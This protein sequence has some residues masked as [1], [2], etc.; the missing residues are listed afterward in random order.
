MVVVGGGSAGIGVTASLLKRRPTLRVAIIEPSDKHYYQPAW[1]LV[2][3]GAYD[4]AE[5]VKPMV[6]IIPRNAEWIQ[7]AASGFDPE[8][9]R[10]HLSDGR[11]M[12]YRQLIVC[13]GIRL[14]WEKI[15]GL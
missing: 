14:A 13:P 1:T 8:H 3:A 4:I 7:I 10:V 12:G 6:D 9:N 15:E 11:V 5:T 2:G